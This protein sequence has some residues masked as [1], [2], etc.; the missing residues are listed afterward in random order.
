[1]RFRKK[2]Y[3]F[4]R[5]G[6]K[7]TKTDN[8]YLAKGGFWLTFGQV[9]STFSSFGLAVAFANLLPPATYGIYQFVLA[10]AGILSAT[11]LSGLNRAAIRSVARGAEGVI[12]ES[13]KI[14][15]RW[16]SLGSLTSLILAGYY[17][18]QSNLTLSISFLVVSF[19]LPLFFS[20]G[21]SSS[22]LKGKKEFGA[23]AKYGAFN[24]IAAVVVMLLALIFSDN[25]FLIL[26]S[27]FG[28]WTLLRFLI[29]KITLRKYQ[30]NQNLDPEI[31]SYGKHLSVMGFIGTIADYLDKLLIFHFFG[32]IEV[33]FYSFAISPVIQLNGL[34]KNVHSLAL[35]KLSIKSKTEI[36]K[37]I[38]GKSL[39]LL[40]F[41]IPL[42]IFYILS[43]PFIYKIFFPNY[44]DSVFFSQI[45]ALTIPL[46][47]FGTLSATALEAQMEVKRKYILTLFSKISKI[48]LMIVLVI[49][50]GI[51]GIIFGTIINYILVVVL[52]F[53]LAIKK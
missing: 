51:L 28:I 37:T 21:I 10:T 26:T 45:F 39:S 3:D 14:K 49:P 1:Q 34:L 46:V 27:Y 9:I 29:F 6:E 41:S 20:L 40:L 4:L 50:Y 13:L 2:T 22:L 18:F 44:I 35:P 12:L 23:D 5:W 38:T 17:F 33:A 47:A 11:T 32:A 8:V 16:G 25:I 53:F 31:K 15:I 36:Q 19:F 48:I 7:Y 30:T 24:Q 42:F 52:A 43:A